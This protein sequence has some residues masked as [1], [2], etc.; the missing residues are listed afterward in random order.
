MVSDKTTVSRPKYAATARLWERLRDIIKNEEAWAVIDE[1]L[2]KF[3]D[4]EVREAFN[5]HYC[6]RDALDMS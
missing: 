2:A 3:S 6:D 1:E 5:H 4:E